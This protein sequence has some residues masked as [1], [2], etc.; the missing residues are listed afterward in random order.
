MGKCIVNL[1]KVGG[2]GNDIVVVAMK[3]III[4]GWVSAEPLF[5]TGLPVYKLFPKV[6]GHL[7]C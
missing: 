6:G 5:G 7:R 2:M 1:G 4:V 3:C